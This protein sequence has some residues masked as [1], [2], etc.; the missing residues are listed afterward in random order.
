MS[1]IPHS[2]R[3]RV[4]DLI[5]ADPRTGNALQAVDDD[6]LVNTARGLA[7]EAILG[8]YPAAEAIAISAYGIPADVCRT[9]ARAGLRVFYPVL[10]ASALNAI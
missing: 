10:S 4:L 7:A 8:G 3:A 1:T 5:H 2:E 6:V 9:I